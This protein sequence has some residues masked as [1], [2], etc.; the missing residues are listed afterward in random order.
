VAPDM[1]GTVTFG[2]GYH[3]LLSGVGYFTNL[4]NTKSS[5]YA[6]QKRLGDSVF[7]PD[8]MAGEGVR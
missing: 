1:P 5:Q 7:T 3:D 2:Y 6:V 4:Q 8:A